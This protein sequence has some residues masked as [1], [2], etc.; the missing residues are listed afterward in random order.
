MLASAALRRLMLKLLESTLLHENWD[1]KLCLK[2]RSYAVFW[3]TE[4]GRMR[5][6]CL[7]AIDAVRVSLQPPGCKQP[8]VTYNKQTC[9]VQSVSKLLV[10]DILQDAIW[11]MCQMANGII[12]MMCDL[13]H[14]ICHLTFSIWCVIRYHLTHVSNGKWH[15]AGYHLTHVSNCK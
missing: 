14:A 15:P 6:H 7:S 2:M 3:T 11:H 5:N 13:T 4:L 10:N 1:T 12:N 8:R 9:S